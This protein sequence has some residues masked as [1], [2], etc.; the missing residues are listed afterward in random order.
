MKVAAITTGTPG[1]TPGG[2]PRHPARFSEAVLRAIV[3]LV[4]AKALLLDPFAGTGRIHQL[5]GARTVGV[6]LEAEWATM[7]T[8]TIIGNALALPFAEDSFDAIATSPC[9]GNRLADH[10]EARD[11]SE[12]RSYRHDLG[13]PLHPNNAGQ[14][15]WG[16][17][18]K[19]FHEKAWAEALR[20]L[21]PRGR[22]ILNVSDHVR[23]GKTQPV[24][25]WHLDTLQR[26]GLSLVARRQVSTPRLRYGAN[27]GAR[28]STEMV[29]LL[30][31]G[32]TMGGAPNP[33]T[34]R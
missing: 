27:A 21:R 2:V 20:V 28:G 4:P 29:A 1:A 7:S 33:L 30:V 8:G 31:K 24:T 3:D 12:R 5:T 32:A 13:R 23:C 15:Q 16:A 22:F 10:H 9:Y 34:G 11:G 14:L 26:L 19:A 18:Y 17:A 6:E 25:A